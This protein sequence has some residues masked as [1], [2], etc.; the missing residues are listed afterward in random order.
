ML[1]GLLPGALYWREPLWLL[2]LLQPAILLILGRLS[3]KN[4]LDC[5]AEPALQPWTDWQV[6]GESQALLPRL[7]SRNTLY[8]LSWLLLAVAMS[9]PRLLL[10][11]P[12]TAEN[13]DLDIM[14]VV[15]VSRSMRARDT[16]P[17]RLQRVK[18]EINELLQRSRNS[19]Y[20]LILYTSRAHLLVPFTHDSRVIGYYLRLID[21]LPMPTH[22][23]LPVTALQ[24]AQQEIAAADGDNDAAIVWMTDGDFDNNSTVAG[25]RLDSMVSELAAASIPLYILGMGSPEGEAIPT[26]DGEWLQQNN[27]PVISRMDD[28]QLLKL[29]KMANGRYIAVQQDDSDWES[30]YDQGMVA[31]KL[32]TDDS[33]DD[34]ETVWLELYPWLLFPAILLIF[35]CLLPFRSRPENHAHSTFVAFIL[36]I[37]LLP[38]PPA[39]A[40][41]TGDPVTASVASQQRAYREFLAENYAE[42]ARLYQQLAGYRNRLGEGGSYYRQQQYQPAIIQFGRAVML[43]DTA[44]QRG[45]AIYNM[46]NATFK[47]GDY[48][49][50][51]SLYRDALLYRPADAATA[52]NLALAQ[53]LQQRVEEQMQLEMANRMG[54]GPRS[55]RARAGIDINS[56]GSITFDNEEERKKADIPLPK[57]PVEELEKLVAL[58]LQHVRLAS[59][60]TGN[61]RKA[62]QANRVQDINTARIRMRELEDRQVLLW[63]RLFEMEEGFPA[64]LEEAKIL[65]GV[66]PW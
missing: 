53:A 41:Q 38:S 4:K 13:P 61:D 26:A 36:L 51:A 47:S 35:I 50:A 55:A 29:A 65:K 18:I 9:G 14:L 8:A 2:L 62:Q 22:G 19:R 44:Q 49:A 1:E 66:E 31:Q 27:R 40:Q 45:T 48:A 15:D 52:N 59:T 39:A 11:Q 37:P 10:E 21:S 32:I 58:G 56:S 7:Y 5:Y 63:K 12:A 43:A 54:S 34:D 57:L 6:K 24:L 23:S 25:I 28:R 3:R 46:A 42:S 30:L 17:D 64:P 20:G 16:E 33:P 60:A